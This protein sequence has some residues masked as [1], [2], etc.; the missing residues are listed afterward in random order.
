MIA[1]LDHAVNGAL[2]AHR[3]IER[4]PEPR[5]PAAR[6]KVFAL[7]WA[8]AFLLVGL[9][10]VWRIGS[11]ERRYLSAMDKR[12]RHETALPALRGEI[13]DRQGRLLA[14]D[15]REHHIYI[16]PRVFR[17][18]YPDEKTRAEKIAL[19]AG[20]I[21]AP[22]AD[23]QS[24]FESPR[25]FVYAKKWLPAATAAR[26]R[27]LGIKAVKTQEVTRR[28]YPA[29]Y[30]AAQVTGFTD[31]RNA[32]VE[33]V[34]R[35]WNKKLAA[36]DGRRV[37]LAM[38]DGREIEVFSQRAPRAGRA[39]DLTIDLRLQY[40]AYRFLE[41]AVAAHGAKSGGA[42]LLD[43]QSGEILAMAG[44]PSFNPNN[45]KQGDGAARRNAAVTDLFEPGSTMKPVVAALAMARGG[46]RANERLRTGAPL[47]IGRLLVRDKTIRPGL[48][49]AEAI[50][51]SSN[52]GAVRMAERL[53]KEQ[54]HQGFSDFGFG[55]KSGILFPLEGRGVLR[56]PDSWKPVE[57][58]TMAYGHG[59]SATLLQLARAYSVFANDGLLARPRLAVGGG[60]E[61][62]SRVL[63]TAIA[64][65]VLRMMEGVTADGGTAPA[66]RVFGYRVAGKTGTAE[67]IGPGG[68]DHDRV[69]AIFVGLAPVSNPRF[70]AAIV[71]DEPRGKIRY[72][73]AVAGPVFS[74]L[75]SEALRLYGIAPDDSQAPAA[76]VGDAV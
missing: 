30:L 68:Y 45:R 27:K 7:F 23:L 26:V 62:K 34:E 14:A 11:D 56:K 67:K 71:I 58:A 18:A 4:K 37:A 39:V 69:R 54:L 36:N 40:L 13:H 44:A 28:F 73:G 64:R 10:G 49:P 75:M 61:E 47:Q 33:G 5:L 60:E 72:G 32:G 55:Q 22:T 57:R 6:V 66:A 17:A 38:R 42:I 74:R 19:L 46:L 31:R 24:K 1:R 25:G 8:A 52:L 12:Y 9:G 29:G 2:R 15:A 3:R 21:D 20:A 35:A 41:R 53:T 63:P 76:L 16:S 59:L 70:V 48:T 51:L 43:A 50:A 65:A